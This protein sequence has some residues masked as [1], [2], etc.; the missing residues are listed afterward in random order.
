M[1]YNKITHNTNSST[2]YLVV[3]HSTTPVN[4][5]SLFGDGQTTGN[6]KLFFNLVQVLFVS[7]VLSLFSLPC[8]TFFKS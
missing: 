1:A 5:R 6:L 2:M 4:L 7:C 8:F 3:L